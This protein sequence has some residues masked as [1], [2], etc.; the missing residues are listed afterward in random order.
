MGRS[1]LLEGQRVL[2]GRLLQAGFRFRHPDLESALRF[3]LGRLAA[4][5]EGVEFHS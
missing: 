3:E 2:P 5:P 1:L 4:P